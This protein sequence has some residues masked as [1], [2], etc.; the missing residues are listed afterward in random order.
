[1]LD[2]AN[3]AILV[4]RVD[5]VV[6]YWNKG[7]ERLYG[8]SAA[9][10]SG[11]D[12]RDLF[13][14]EATAFDA[15][16]AAL[17]ETGQWTG[18]LA[19]RTRSG[20]RLIAEGSWTLIAGDGEHAHSVL[21]INTDVTEKK[22][23]EARLFHGQRLESLGVLASGIAHDF[24]NLLTAILGNV[25]M[26]KEDLTPDHPAKEPL[27]EIEKASRRG[28][29]LVRQL[30]TFGRR[31]EPRRMRT[32]LT[33]P[34]TEALGLLRP[35]IPTN[36][37]VETRFER[38][39]PEVLVDATQIHQVVMNLSTN[40]VHAMAPGGGT[41]TVRVERVV[42]D[43]A[44][45]VRTRVL[46]AGTYSR[47]VVSDTGAGMDEAMLDRIFDP[48][49]TTKNAGEGSGLG[50]SV[51]HGIVRNHDGGIEV[52]STPG[53]GTTF[54]LYFPAATPAARGAA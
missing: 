13:Y 42:L 44:L 46:P 9:E 23:L 30:L 36:V 10:A 25:T 28:S 39:A 8:W 33:L 45:D 19:Q 11:R 50:L 38:D 26:A 4:R 49:F 18:E 22:S 6:T 29:D 14:E 43:R 51:V 24:N 35:A 21:V 5:G 16:Q 48:F 7:A 52:V 47:L 31:Q 32:T 27:S 40:A 2:K 1:L 20:R 17:L 3:D 41:L 54:N 34:V 12:V 53:S 37:H 15:A